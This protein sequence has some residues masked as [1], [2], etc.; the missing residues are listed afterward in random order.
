MRSFVWTAIVLASLRSV[1][2]AGVVNC[3]P[4]QLEPD[5][6]KVTLLSN[7]TVGKIYVDGVGLIGGT[8]PVDYVTDP[9]KLPPGVSLHEND[10]TIIGTPT[11]A[12]LYD[13]TI[14]AT[15]HE[16]CS[17]ANEYVTIVDDVICHVTVLPSPL[18]IAKIPVRED[19]REGFR[20]R[21]GIPPYTYSTLSLPDGLT[22]N[23]DTGVV[24]GSP[25]K[26]GIYSGYVLAEDA[27]GC[28]NSTQFFY[29]VTPPC[30]PP[31]LFADGEDD[32]FYFDDVRVGAG[33][34]YYGIEQVTGGTPPYTLQVAGNVPPGITPS[35]FATAPEIPNQFTLNGR[36]LEVGD[37]AFTIQITDANGCT[38][39][40]AYSFTVLSEREVLQRLRPALPRPVT[41]RPLPE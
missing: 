24:S 22:I 25:T 16:G 40:I 41:D 4:L 15:D 13:Y 5:F 28:T 19:F 18:A 23:R 31:L 30:D 20:G 21:G 34:G 9:S 27:D 10:G 39:N 35:L 17:I 11:K 36:F 26:P 2:I 1:A 7:G 33:G 6:G 29:Q 14:T 3:P 38:V 37:Y 12:G 8:P 32:L